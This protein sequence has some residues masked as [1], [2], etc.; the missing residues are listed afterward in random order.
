[1]SSWCE[2]EPWLLKCFLQVKEMTSVCL[3]ISRYCG[4]FLYSRGS[5]IFLYIKFTGKGW[6]KKKKKSKF[7]GL[8]S[9]IFGLQGM[10]Q[11]PRIFILIS[12]VAW[13]L[14]LHS[15]CF[16]YNFQW[17]KPVSC[18]DFLDAPAASTTVGNSFS[19][20]WLLPIFCYMLFT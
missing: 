19:S 14:P 2:S 3:G 15:T 17:L 13:L 1:M 5:Q 9:Q 12:L 7:P 20:W 8:Q 4:T 16:L 11:T 6:Q 10:W 18:P